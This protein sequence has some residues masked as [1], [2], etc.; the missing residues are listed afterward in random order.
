MASKVQHI[1]KLADVSCQIDIAIYI[2]H[3]SDAT[4]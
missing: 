3:F 2:S 4:D 1:K